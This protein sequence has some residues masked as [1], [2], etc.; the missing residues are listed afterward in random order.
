M[1]ADLKKY[2]PDLF[3]ILDKLN[4]K[5]HWYNFVFLFMDYG[6]I[7]LS[8]AASIGFHN[9]FIYFISV[10][11]IGSRMRALENLLHETSHG[12][13]FK[14]RFLNNTL[15]LFLCA[16]PIG[17]SLHAY[18][19]SHMAHHTY[20]GN[21]EKDPD[22][23]RYTKIGVDAL[24]FEKNRL[25]AR[26][27]RVIFL[28]D[29]LMYLKNTFSSFVYVKGTPMKELGMR[30][31]FFFIASAVILFQGWGVYFVLYWVIPFLAP[32]QVIRFF[33][34][35][36]EHGGLYRERDEIMMTR[37]NLINPVARFFIYPHGDAY[38]LTHHLL[39]AVPH[40]HLSRAHQILMNWDP[41]AKAHHCYGY[42]KAG[43]TGLPVSFGEM[44]LEGRQQ[45]VTG[46]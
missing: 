2:R 7:F 38:H 10:L 12:A 43:L 40:Y 15:G 4:K 26:F 42:F 36:S 32:L 11:V 33:S 27:L 23:I 35:I 9:P 20:L 22:L 41:Y 28:R 19:K 24:P 1:I 6:L 8:I 13:L 25:I 29:S 44:V 3:R 5:S 37:N 14:S 18:R 45:E 34:E 17:S 21:K 46:G 31:C 16:F 39:P 30:L